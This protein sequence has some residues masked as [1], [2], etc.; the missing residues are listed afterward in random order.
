MILEYSEKGIVFFPDSDLA[1]TP[2]DFGL[3]IRGR[4]L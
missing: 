4:L 3:G 1:G 2:A